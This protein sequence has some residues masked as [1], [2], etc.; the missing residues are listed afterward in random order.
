VGEAAAHFLVELLARRPPPE[1]RSF[2]TEIVFRGSTA[3]RRE[4]R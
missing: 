2:P 1:S 4:D 3:R